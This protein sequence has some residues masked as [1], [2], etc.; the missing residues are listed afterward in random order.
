MTIRENNT[1][2]LQDHN[3]SSISETLSNQ[4]L[5]RSYRSL[6]AFASAEPTNAESLATT[7]LPK[8]DDLRAD[9][10]ILGKVSH[11]CFRQP[12]PV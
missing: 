7:R 6:H 8:P 12:V 2:F 10:P 9:P 5:G 1:N 11:N 3:R 4:L